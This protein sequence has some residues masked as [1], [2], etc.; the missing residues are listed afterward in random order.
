MGAP[1]RA[2][3]VWARRRT[4]LARARAGSVFR[5]SYMLFFTLAALVVALAAGSGVFAGEAKQAS[6][7]APA[8]TVALVMTPTFD[9]NA[10]PLV[11]TYFL[12]D[13]EDYQKALVATEGNLIFREIL[14]SYDQEVLLVRD[15][16]EERAAY[17]AIE[18]A[19][20]RAIGARVVVNDLRQGAGA[21]NYAPLR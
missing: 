15:A 11:I 19:K 20:A 1:W 9:P 4:K 10:P 16:D 14:R 8:P 17:A 2:A 21:N 18:E 5:Q 7:P 12:V 3:R 6:V 13:T